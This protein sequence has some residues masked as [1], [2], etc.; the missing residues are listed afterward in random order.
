M[1][2]VKLFLISLFCLIPYSLQAMDHT[3]PL[4]LQD[5]FYKE[6]WE[7]HF[8][9][10]DGTFVTAQFLVANFP[11][12]VGKEHGIMLATVVTPDGKRTIIKNGRNFGEWGFDA[13]KFD[14]FIHNHWLKS[15]DGVYE[16]YMAAGDKSKVTNRVTS[17]IAPLDHARF[18]NKA[19]QLES[20]FYLP[21]FEGEGTWQIFQDID[22]P[23]KAGAGKVQ[24]FATHVVINGRLEGLLKGWLRMSGL[25]GNDDQPVPFLSAMTRADGTEDIILTLKSGKA[26]LTK[27]TEV[28]LDYKDIINGDDRSSSPTRIDVKARNGKETVTGTIHFKRKIDHFNISD[29]LNFFEGSFAASRA[30]V[31]NYRYIADYDLIYTTEGGESQHLTGQALSE[32][33]DIL[34]PKREKKKKRRR[35]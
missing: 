14:I 24:G 17:A 12:P 25:R 8:L 19:G 7:E 35:R 26:D 32:Y 20:S 15:K 3:K 4:M 18:E 5:K 34:P 11:W 13:H 31:T 2:L 6:Y 1:K 23:L 33:A 28:K 30:S 9:F 21:Y 16:F 22:K 10:D 27:F 29:H